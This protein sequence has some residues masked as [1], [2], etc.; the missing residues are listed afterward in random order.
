[1]GPVFCIQKLT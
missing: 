1:L